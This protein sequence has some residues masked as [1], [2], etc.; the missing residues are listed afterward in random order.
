MWEPGTAH[1]YHA[2]TYGWLAGELVRRVDP[3][4]RSLG[5][6]VAEEI[7]APVGGGAEL[8]IGLPDAAPGASVAHLSR[9]RRPRTPRSSR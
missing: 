1:G 4:G 6:F 2:L 8:W 3:A 9:R 5:T 7:V